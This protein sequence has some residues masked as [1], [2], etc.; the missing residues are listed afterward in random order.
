MP[1]DTMKSTSEL[2]TLVILI[3][4]SKVAA[5]MLVLGNSIS[6]SLCNC[7]FSPAG[8]N[9]IHSPKQPKMIPVGGEGPG[10][11][12]GSRKHLCGR[13]CHYVPDFGKIECSLNSL[14]N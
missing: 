4:E 1:V 12:Q 6:R 3:L 10:E 13:K 7:C 9:I 11:E 5:L 14:W 8:R 2:L